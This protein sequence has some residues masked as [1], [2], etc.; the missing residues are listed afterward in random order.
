[1]SSRE[2]LSGAMVNDLMKRNVMWRCGD[3]MKRDV[4]CAPSRNTALD[5]QGRS[6]MRALQ[7][8]CPGLHLAALC[9]SHRRDHPHTQH[10]T[11]D[12]SD[13]HLHRARTHTHTHRK[14]SL[15]LSLSLSLS[16]YIFNTQ[17]LT[18]TK[19]TPTH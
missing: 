17:S 6:W 10:N 5:R 12:C 16:I 19:A 9:G 2:E 4:M 13:L 15:A 3:E 1:M 8:R 11:K 18:H 14:L 7:V